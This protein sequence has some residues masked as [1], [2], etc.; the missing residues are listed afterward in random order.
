MVMRLALIASF[1]VGG[2][3]AQNEEARYIVYKATTLSSAVEKITV[4]QPAAGAKKVTFKVVVIYCSAACTI[5]FS[6]SGTAATTTTLAPVALSPNTPTSTVTGW[7]GSDAG[8][9]TALWTTEIAAGAIAS[10][11]VTGIVLSGAVLTQ[12][13]SV[14][15]ASM[16]GTVK[17]TIVWTER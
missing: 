4:Q 12:N 11:D 2:L 9:G 3:C 10:I 7:S 17:I 14:A 16:T 6:R 8:S 13:F 5:T 1:L 15:T